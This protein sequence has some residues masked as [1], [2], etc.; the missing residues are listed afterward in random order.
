MQRHVRSFRSCNGATART[1]SKIP[2]YADDRPEGQGPTGTA[3]REKRNYICNDF[4]HDPRTLLWRKAAEQ[5]G[6]Q[7]SASFVIRQGGVICGAIT[8]Y[9]GETDFF[10]DKE[11]ALLEEAAADISFALDNFVREAA[12]R[13]AEI[14]LRWK[15]AFLEA[16]VDSSLDGIL[17]VNDQGK[18]IL[19]NQ[20]LNELWKIPPEIAGNQDDSVQIKFVADRTK[21]PWEFADKVAYLYLHPDEVSRDEIELV[22]GMF[23]DRYSSPVRDKAGKHYGRIWTFR[24]ISGRKRVEEAL[25]EGERQLA[26]LMSNLPGMVYRCRNDQDWTVKFVSTGAQTLT[27]YSVADLTGNRAVAFASLIHPDDREAVWNEVQAA[28]K[29]EKP[30]MLTYRLRMA[31]GA[32]RWVWEQGQG[33]FDAE[34]QLLA[35]EGF[36]TDITKRKQA[37]LALEIRA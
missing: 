17:V 29:Q 31:T 26:T 21:N 36:I 6:F 9:A 25:R 5:A 1:I 28:L 16:Q 12:R 27:G 33:I 19:Q 20:R 22:D 18:K 30:F 37:E 32:E 34:H 24:D 2:V 35:L 3:I 14:E 13:Q 8:V 15:T 7:S 10:Q 11:I 23:L 4:S